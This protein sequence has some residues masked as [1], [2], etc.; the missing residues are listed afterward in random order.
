MIGSPQNNF[1]TMQPPQQTPQPRNVMLGNAMSNQMS[2][3]PMQ[4]R[5]PIGN[6]PAYR[7]PQQPQMGGNKPYQ[8]VGA[9]NGPFN[10]N[11]VQPVNQPPQMLDQMKQMY[12]GQPMP[13]GAVP[14]FGQQLAPGQVAPTQAEIDRLRPMLSSPMQQ[15]GFGQQLAP[16][17]TAPT[18]AEIDRLRPMLSTPMAPQGMPQPAMLPP[19]QYGNATPTMPNYEQPQSN[20]SFNMQPPI[21]NMQ[22]SQ[23]GPIGM[24][25]Q[26]QNRFG[27]GLA[28]PT[29]MPQ[30]TQVS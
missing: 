13:P 28:R 25:Q 7:P 14:G 16:G 20:A 15:P 30:A 1:Q 22:P 21:P 23:Q 27:V 17:Q 11:P 6:M 9:N 4:P 8:P 12:Q 3:Q 5:Q 24:N 29:Q 10:P 2:R 18:Q 26:G 19:S